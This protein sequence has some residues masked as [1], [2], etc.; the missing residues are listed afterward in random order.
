MVSIFIVCS[1]IYLRLSFIGRVC[2][3]QY[4]WRCAKP[5]TITHYGEKKS[6]LCNQCSNNSSATRSTYRSTNESSKIIKSSDSSDT[7]LHRD[8]SNL[9]SKASAHSTPV[10]AIRYFDEKQ[11]TV[12]TYRTAKTSE[13]DDYL[14]PSIDDHEYPANCGK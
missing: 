12:Q 13:L 11:Q 6:F 1:S 9:P 2:Q 5:E 10:N 8:F 7:D 3:N 14:T 4:H